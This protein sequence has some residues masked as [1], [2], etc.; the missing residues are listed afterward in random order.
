MKKIVNV[1]GKNIGEGCPCYFMA[2][3]AG[4]YN[5]EEE[6]VRIV[7]SCV[8][9]G[10]DA[11]KFQT[12]DPETITTKNNFFDMGSVGQ[13]RQYDVFVEYKIEP[14]LQRFLVDYC[15][16]KKI[17]VFTAPSHMDDLELI[18]SFNPP[19]Y[20][21][22]SDLAT[23]IPLL[24]RI[25][26][27]GKPIFL[28][29]GMCTM[30]EV[31]KSVEAIL[32]T[33]NEN[34]LLFHCISNYPA[35]PEE[36]NLKAILTM[37]EKFDCPVGFSDHTVGF[38]LSLAA[39]AMGADMIERHYWC[40]GNTEGADR[41]ISLDEKQFREM[42][43]KAEIIQRAMG[44]G[45]KK[46]VESELK[47]MQKNRISI[48]VMKDLEKGTVIREDMIDIRRPGTGL[49]PEMW[50]RVIGMKI[51]ED[52]SAETPLQASHVGLDLC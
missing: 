30:K 11:V 16:K 5:S 27:S 14:A 3:I 2:E 48:I 26:E 33:G 19:A 7:D 8:R 42:R 36:Q 13:K 52:L 44:N 10:A 35:E 46:P 34:I 49:S 21:I 1:D 43:E 9:S 20:K 23:H 47:N 25:G 28:S 45:E 40:E 12:L 51:L 4:N 32:S 41:E 22:G 18:D 38:D 29:T 31:E 15:N 17:T 39:V 37:K 6:T 50:D 24:K